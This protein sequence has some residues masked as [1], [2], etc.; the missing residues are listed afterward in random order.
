V[1]IVGGA[2]GHRHSKGAA[3]GRDSTLKAAARVESLELRERRAQVVVRQLGPVNVHPGVGKDLQQQQQQ[4]QQRG[5]EGP[6]GRGQEMDIK[7]RAQHRAPAV[8]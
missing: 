2:W 3:H 4:Q 7:Q 1:V 8:P 5:C 6:V